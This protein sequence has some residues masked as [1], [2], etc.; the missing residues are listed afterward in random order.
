MSIPTS[1]TKEKA[2]IY[3]DTEKCNGCGNCV[4][5]CKDFSLE[6]KNGKVSLSENPFFGCIGCG[7]CM[8]ICQQ[9]AISIKGRFTSRS[10]LF[11]LHEIH[12]TTDYTALIYLLKRRRSIREFKKVEVEKEIIKKIIA[13]ATHSPMGIPPSD[14]N[15]MVLDSF[16]KVKMFS[17]DYCRFL[18]NYKWMVS[19]WFL[20]IMRPF[21]GKNNDQLFR[22]FVKPLINKFSDTVEK[23]EDLFTYNAPVALYFYGSPFTDPADPIIAATYA[24]I[25]AESLGLGSCMIGSFHPM[26][27]YGKKGK[28]FRDKYNIRFKSREGLIVI[29]GYSNVHYKYGIHRNFAN[30]DWIQ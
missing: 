22:K 4:E 15:V 1:R 24:M 8:C 19:G 21:W 18:S 20:T 2:N 3:I 10:H 17:K 7:H 12:E 5:V 13:A 9:D 28:Q 16:E 29:L 25:A 23:E 11:S 26:I 27:Q 30:V 6:I 14:V